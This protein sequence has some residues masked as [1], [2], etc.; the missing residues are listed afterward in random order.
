MEETHTAVL[1]ILIKSSR[2]RT[3]KNKLIVGDIRKKIGT[4]VAG[5]YVT[6]QGNSETIEPVKEGG[7]GIFDFSIL[8]MF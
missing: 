8:A 4:S 5:S 2:V 6:D 7:I 3:P 1:I